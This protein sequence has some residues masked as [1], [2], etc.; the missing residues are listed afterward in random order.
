MDLDDSIRKRLKEAKTLDVGGPPIDSQATLCILADDLD[1]DFVSDA[2]GCQP[3]RS[4]RKG[5]R[6]SDRPRIPPAPIGQWFLEAPKDLSFVDKIDF[7]LDSTTDDQT[8]WK[9]LAE[10]YRLKLNG[11]IFLQ[12]WTEGFEL[13]N[14]TLARISFRNWSFGLSMYSAEGEEIIE[15]FLKDSPASEEKRE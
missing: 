9:T 1:P 5:E 10:S 15:S 13:P 2:V 8:V 4:R 3:T 7:L 12:S 14:A 11:A 6:Y